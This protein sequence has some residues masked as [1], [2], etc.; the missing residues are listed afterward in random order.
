MP[1]FPDVEIESVRPTETVFYLSGT[2]TSM[3]NAMRRMMI[4]ETPT[5]AID[6][7]EIY[8]NSSVLHDEFLSHRLGMIPLVSRT[9]DEFNYTRDCPCSEHCPSCSVELELNVE[10]KDDTLDVTSSMLR[11][12]DPNVRPVED[13]QFPKGILIC[14]LGRGQEIKLKAIAKKGVGKEHAKWSPVATV[15]YKFEPEI[16]INEKLMNEMSDAELDLWVG[17]EEHA[18]SLVCPS[19]V[20]GLNEQHKLFVKDPWACSYCE[21]CLKKAEAIKKP[22]LITVQ[23]KTPERFRFTVETTGSLPPEVIVKS[24]LLQLRQK[25]SNLS[26]LLLLQNPESGDGTNG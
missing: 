24:A 10:C 21:E 15:V 23:Q 19:N 1:R 11:S 5:M 4:A 16:R 6:L 26:E 3:A 14:K 22:D 25:I 20:F 2:D 13:E 8:S 7:V 18:T 9:V 12:S 17:N